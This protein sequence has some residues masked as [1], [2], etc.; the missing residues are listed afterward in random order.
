VSTKVSQYHD[1]VIFIKT[2]T[3]VM[4]LNIN[5]QA[6]PELLFQ[7]KTDNIRYDFEVNQ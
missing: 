4:A 5:E 3:G 1:E 7:V 6:F 2:K